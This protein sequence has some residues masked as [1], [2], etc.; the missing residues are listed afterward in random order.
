MTRPI[1]VVMVLLRMVFIMTIAV[2]LYC[3]KV[4]IDNDYNSTVASKVVNKDDKLEIQ[5][6]DQQL[7]WFSSHYQ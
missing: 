4:G 7:K 2:L 3:Y 6:I 5:M 1:V